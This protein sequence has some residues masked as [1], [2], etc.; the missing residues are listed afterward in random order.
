MQSSRLHNISDPHP[1]S[2]FSNFS[3]KYD[4]WWQFTVRTVEMRHRGSYL[5]VLW[6]VLNPLLMLGLYMFVF[7]FI[8]KNKFGVL[9]NET[10]LDFAL[11]MFLGLVLFQVTSETLGIGPTIIVSSPN[12]VKKVVFPLEVLPLAQTGASWFHLLISLLLLFAGV[13]IAG[14]TL[15]LTGLLWLPVLLAPYLLFTAGLSWFMAAL[16]VFFRDINQVI[17][18][19]SNI[20]LWASAVFYPVSRI[21]SSPLV[22][23]VLRWNPFLQTVQLTRDALLWHERINLASLAYIYV[24]GLAVFFVGGWFFKKMQ[25]AFADVL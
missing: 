14:R 11:A 24:V 22:W 3:R 17:A 16:G 8:F 25:P 6:S 18:F 7:G 21:R 15:T 20:V 4:L 12:L 19:I 10:S 23:S 9:P 5:G 13:L 1:P 2:F